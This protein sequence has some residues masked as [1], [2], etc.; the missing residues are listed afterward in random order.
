MTGIMLFSGI[1]ACPR[2]VNVGDD[3]AVVAIQ[4][5]LGNGLRGGSGLVGSSICQLQGQAIIRDG[6]RY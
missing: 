1:D 2:I 6:T 5:P 4:P 3:V